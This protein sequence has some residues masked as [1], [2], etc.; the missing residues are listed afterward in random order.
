MIGF[1]NGVLGS[2]RVV[3][4]H[5]ELIPGLPR[6]TPRGSLYIPTSATEVADVVDED[7][8]PRV[9]RDPPG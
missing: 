9:R 5:L 7:V 8:P 6:R 3:A 1:A 2:I 4:M